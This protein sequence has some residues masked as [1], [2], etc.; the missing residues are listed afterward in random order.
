MITVGEVKEHCII[1]GKPAAKIDNENYY[2]YCSDVCFRIHMHK[3]I[4]IF[5][6]IPLQI[7]NINIKK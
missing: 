2:G 6:Y 1:C 5:P 7:S 4:F 3:K